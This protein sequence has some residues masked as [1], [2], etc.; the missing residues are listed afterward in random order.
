MLY[1]IINANP[2]PLPVPAALEVAERREVAGVAQQLCC[3]LARVVQRYAVDLH[4]Q[5]KAQ[6]VRV[7][8]QENKKRKK[9]KK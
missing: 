2:A 5:Y 7:Q 4:S 1:D 9:S 8:V 6:Q 3:T